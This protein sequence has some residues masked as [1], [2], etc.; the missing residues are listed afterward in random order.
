[1]S[2]LKKMIRI[3]SKNRGFQPVSRPVRLY[4]KLLNAF[5]ENVRQQSTLFQDFN[6]VRLSVKTGLMFKKSKTR[7]LPP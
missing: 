4:K 5:F 6:I 2:S 7:R 3:G 1:M